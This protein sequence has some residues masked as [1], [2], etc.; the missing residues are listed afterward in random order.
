MERVQKIIAA[1]GVA[2]RRGAEQLILAG[3]VAVNGQV[4]TLLGTQVNPERDDV[5]V[6]G[7]SISRPAKRTIM[8]NKPMGYIT[9][10][11]DPHARDTVMA[12]VPPIPG[13]HPIGRLDKDTTGLLLFTN[14]GDLTFA[15]AHPR[16]HVEKTYL[17]TVQGH[18]KA[19]AL[20]RL[21][22]GVLLDDG[23]TAPAQVRL[24]RPQGGAS[25]LEITI[26]EGRK[27]Q[28]RR[29]CQ[30]I[31][32]PAMALARLALGPLALGNLPVGRWR[33]LTPAELD[34]LYDATGIPSPSTTHKG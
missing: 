34:A 20:E 29:M 28:V 17:A 4:I 23:P 1:T 33:D 12:L 25:L 16:H 18:P 14:D 8:L 10:C 27:R 2:S 11:R 5:A 3:R 31:N 24:V 32:H 15:L 22:Q 21:R 6:D 19:P 13:L 7:M 30:A 9:T 26:H